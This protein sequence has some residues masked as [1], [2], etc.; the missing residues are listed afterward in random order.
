MTLR[1][2]KNARA[3][4]RFELVKGA[5]HYSEPASLSNSIHNTLK[6]V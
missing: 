5:L 1:E 6:M 4:M 3:S 2:D